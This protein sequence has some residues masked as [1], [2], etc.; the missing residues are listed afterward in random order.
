MN[1]DFVA[2]LVNKAM[3]IS[4]FEVQKV[5]CEGGAE[6]QEEMLT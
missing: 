3:L 6:V 5:N 4:N 1:L 2:L